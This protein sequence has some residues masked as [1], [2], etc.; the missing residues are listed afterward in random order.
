MNASNFMCNECGSRSIQSASLWQ[1]ALQNCILVYHHKHNTNRPKFKNF[2]YTQLAVLWQGF[3]INSNFVSPCSS[4]GNFGASRQSLQHS[5]HKYHL[6]TFNL[7]TATP[8]NINL[9]DMPI[10]ISALRFYVPFVSFRKMATTRNNSHL[11]P[12]PS[13]ILMN[14]QELPFGGKVLIHLLFISWPDLI[15]R[16][17]ATT[18][19]GGWS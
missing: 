3:N 9:V 16:K 1:R 10:H 12:S 8:I 15:T 5:H 17:A 14:E 4:S 18:S 6:A 7:F 13:P 19:G 11:W 2:L